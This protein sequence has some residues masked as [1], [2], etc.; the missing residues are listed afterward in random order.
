M[1]KLH[2]EEI[3]E[4]LAY[5]NNKDS[6]DIN[7]VKSFFNISVYDVLL[8]HEIVTVEYAKDNPSIPYFTLNVK[9]TENQK[10]AMLEYFIEQLEE[11]NRKQNV[12]ENEY[13]FADN[14]ESIVWDFDTK[15]LLVDFKQKNSLNN[16]QQN[17]KLQYSI[18]GETEQ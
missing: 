1:E 14:M 11:C 15:K 17:N 9:L 5:F 13:P 6:S 16:E 18:Y 2:K 3:A 8:K 7:V 10:I 4:S 12:P